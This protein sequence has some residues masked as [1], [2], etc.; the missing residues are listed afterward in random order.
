[1]SKSSIRVCVLTSAHPPFDTRIFHKEA[2]SLAKAGYNVSLIVQHDRNEIVNGVR[3]ISFPKPRNRLQRMTR[4]VWKVFILSLKE[5]ANVYHFHDPELIPLGLLLKLTRRKV[6]YDIHEDYITS[7]EQKEY[8]PFFLRKILANVIGRIEIISSRL[9]TLILAEKYYSERFPHGIEVL[10]YPI[11]K[12]E[13]SKMLMLKKD[14]DKPCLIYTGGISIDRGALIHANIVNLM[15][16]VEVWMV[17]SCSKEL[18]DQLY[19]IAGKRSA[20]LHIEGVG[21]HVPYQRI[22][23]YYKTRKWAA[24]LAVFPPTKH[25]LRKELTKLFEYMANEIPIISSNFPTWRNIVEGEQCGVCADPLKAEEITEAIQF[26]ISHPAEADQMGKNGR[27]AVE[28]KYNWEMEEKK[29]LVFY[30]KVLQAM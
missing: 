22:L 8:L 30:K 1:M 23:E 26:I 4:T 28:E 5:N 29:M 6:V 2:S 10:N 17:G 20:R 25:Y 9:F 14:A 15:P 19:D 18:A 7:I 13:I 27:R 21:Y 24:G 12:R 3:I 16:D 11:L